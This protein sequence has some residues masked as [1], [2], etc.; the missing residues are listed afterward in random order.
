MEIY[1]EI[2][3]KRQRFAT[4]EPMATRSDTFWMDDGNIILQA[5]VLFSKSIRER[6]LGTRQFFV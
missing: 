6:S 1:Y 2:G 3:R 5:E 4:P